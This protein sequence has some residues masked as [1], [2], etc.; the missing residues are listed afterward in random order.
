M[1]GFRTFAVT[2]ALAAAVTLSSSAEPLPPGLPELAVAA[3]CPMPAEEAGGPS[4]DDSRA[5]AAGI[6]PAY[7]GS[8][9]KPTTIVERLRARHVPGV[10]VA[11]I[12]G[13][14]L[15]WARG[16]GLRDMATCQ[17]VTPVTAFQAG[18]IS[19]TFA[20]VLA[21]RQVEKGTL[22]L[23]AD[24][25]QALTRW[26]LPADSRF[27]PGFVTLR[28]LLSH[29]S[30]VGVGGF[31][32]YPP[33]APLPTLVEILDGKPPET[34]PAIRLEAVPGAAFSYS[35]GGY[36]IV[37]AALED[38]TRTPF[39][40]LAAREILRPLGMTR[41][42]FVQPPTAAIL[43]D[44]AT[45]HH[46]G[47]PFKDKF[48]IDPELAAAGLWATPSDLGRFLSD[49]R[50]A[51]AGES[52]HLVKP[53]TASGMLKPVAG[54]WGLGFEFF[55]DGPDRLFGH[56]GVNWGYISQMQ[57]DPQSGDGIVIMT[58]GEQGLTLAAEIIRAAANHYGW[59]KFR[60]RPLMDTLLHQTLYLRGSMNDWST[61]SPLKADGQYTW[62]A[63]IVLAAGDYE[64]K[65]GSGD[66]KLALGSENT[67]TFAVPARDIALT[68]E[69]GNLQIK[70]ITA[71]N[72]RVSFHA[73]DTGVARL[74]IIPR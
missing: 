58:N 49:I 59:S 24:I 23:D 42:S 63:D 39:S 16:W 11:V 31:T 54:D 62:T 72:Y 15:A 67:E 46:Q 71:G 44:A 26:H 6:V 68:A 27:P 4:T 36:M 21:M 56:G 5:I 61:A 9:T 18:S 3:N 74:S 70:I 66:W 73:D 41:S 47:R 13:G 40:D 17:P 25:N 52:G 32:G 19:K 20:A 35:G 14:K 37:Q 7:T 1:T 2:A 51:A 12:R 29:T 30:G 34:R 57:I 33:G 64:L 28:Q 65:V 55:G 38:V 60:S 69:S 50:A 22:T 10:S 8:A 43:A 45:G 53:Q 48:Y